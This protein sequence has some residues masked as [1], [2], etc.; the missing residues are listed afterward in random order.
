MNQ[1]DF[2]TY[3]QMVKDL[4]NTQMNGEWGG[5]IHAVVGICGEVGELSRAPDRKNIQEESGDLEFY[6]EAF[7]QQCPKEFMDWT[8]PVDRRME[9]IRFGEVLGNLHTLSADLLDLCKKPW[10]Y[11]DKRKPKFEEMKPLY[12]AL[13]FNLLA[14]YDFLGLDSQDLRKANQIKLIGN[15]GRYKSG[16]FSAEAAHARADKNGDSSLG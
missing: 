2:P 1:Q 14:F 13:F 16:Q 12:V 11:P 5:L 9:N 4:F 7:I 6:M 8:F 15:S 10:A 3:T